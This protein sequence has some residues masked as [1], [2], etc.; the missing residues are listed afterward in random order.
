MMRGAG[1]ASAEG[2]GIVDGAGSALPHD[3]SRGA[4]TDNH[5]V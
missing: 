2:C 4:V 5:L 1:Y 3:E